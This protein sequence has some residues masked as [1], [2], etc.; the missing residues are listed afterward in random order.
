M[1]TSDKPSFSNTAARCLQKL[2]SWPARQLQPP[3]STSC[4]V[5]TMYL[6][7]NP[8]C[9]KIYHAHRLWIRVYLSHNRVD[10]IKMGVY[11]TSGTL[12]L[13][14]KARAPPSST[15][16]SPSEMSRAARMAA[17]ARLSA[18]SFLFMPHCGKH[19]TL[20]HDRRTHITAAKRS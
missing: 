11:R 4:E 6:Q 3:A 2:P 13:V 7:H 15:V 18:L 16:M 12:L 17:V 10:S 9:R 14:T 5:E 20:I 8:Q 1:S 19:N